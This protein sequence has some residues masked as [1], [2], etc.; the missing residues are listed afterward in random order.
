MME[1]DPQKFDGKKRQE[2][3]TMKMRNIEKTKVTEKINPEKTGYQTLDFN[4]M[5]QMSPEQ[6]QAIVD[7]MLA[8][9][10]PIQR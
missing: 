10:H 1:I 4:A 6:L 5:I 3:Y 8:D 2:V 9:S 7:A